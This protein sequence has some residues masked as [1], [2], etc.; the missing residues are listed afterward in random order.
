LVTVDTIK[1]GVSKSWRIVVDLSMVLVP[2]MLAV[3]V[4]EAVGIMDWL[5]ALAQPVMDIFS[6]PGEAAVALVLGY[7]IEPY[8][9]AAVAVGLGLGPREMTIVGTMLMLCHSLV[10]ET[11]ILGKAGA[12]TTLVLA[13]RLVSSLLAG[14]M[15]G[16]VL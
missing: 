11:A 16:L 1:R 7:I 14:W 15:L 3:T 12:R 5:A 6:L 9:A 2:C 13:V 10:L 4:L 8:A